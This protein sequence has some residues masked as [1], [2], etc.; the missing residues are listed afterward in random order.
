MYIKTLTVSDLN[1]YLKKILDNDFILANLC[2]K[3]EIYNLK[4]HTSGHIYFSLKD[5][6]SKINCVMF[7][8]A[9]STLNFIPENGMKVVVKGRVSVYK[10][11]GVYQLYC[12]EMQREGIGELYI[13]F[14]KLKSKL[15]KEGLFEESHKKNIPLYSKNIG[16]ITSP[17]GAAM[18]DIINVT[19]RRNPKINIKLYPSLV[20]GDCAVQNIIDGINRLNNIENIDVIII[21][22]GGGSVEDLWCFNDE[23]LARAIYKSSKPIITGIG[24]E[25]DYTIADFVSDR[26]APTPSAA[27]EIAVFD[28]NEFENKI[29]NFRNL[30]YTKMKSRLNNEVNNL[31]IVLKQ[32]NSNS[33]LIYMANQYNNLDRLYELLNIKVKGKFQ[34]EREKLRN[35]DSLLSA[36]NPLNILKKGYAVIEDKNKK[37]VS[38]IDVLSKTKK[39]SIILKDGRKSFTLQS[40]NNEL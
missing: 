15:S 32:L 8:D 12:N 22:R 14:E 6:Y 19:M 13:A 34:K 20:Q 4:F 38:S 5:E 23:T 11:E 36:N 24:H 18:R 7:K 1:N 30:L 26:R 21:A 27:A 9:A 17:T 33:P 40:D 29:L 39:V 25:I 28:I 3:G 31:E 16:V 10:K 37:V 2:I 35:I